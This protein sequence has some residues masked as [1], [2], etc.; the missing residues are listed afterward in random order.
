MKKLFLI[1]F[2]GALTITLPLNAQAADDDDPQDQVTN[3]THNNST[4]DEESDNDDYDDSSDD[5]DNSDKSDKDN[6][7]FAPI[8]VT[9]LSSAFSVSAVL[10][11]YKS[12]Q[13]PGTDAKLPPDKEIYSPPIEDWMKEYPSG[14]NVSPIEEFLGSVMDLTDKFHTFSTTMG[15]R[16]FDIK[17]DPILT[18]GKD[19]S[20]NTGRKD[21]GGKLTFGLR[22]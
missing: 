7:I 4:I 5:Q 11:E 14:R 20:D 16:K 2:L 19:V 1:L 8:K 18:G 21:L 9:F 6:P 13:G 15:N 12:G 17:I 10:S 22:Y 3:T